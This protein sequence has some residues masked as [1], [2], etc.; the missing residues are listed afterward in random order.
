MGLTQL[1]TTPPP[2]SSIGGYLG[3]YLGVSLLQVS[4]ELYEYFT[5]KNT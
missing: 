4:Q 2:Q 1:K 3:L 5:L